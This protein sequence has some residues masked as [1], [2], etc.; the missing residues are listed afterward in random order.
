[1]KP[2]G[3]AQISAK[4]YSGDWADY[5]EIHSFL[6]PSKSACAHFKHRFLLHHAEG[7]ELAVRIFG[8][9]ITN[10]ENRIILTKQILTD[11]LIE[12][13]GRI[14]TIE[15]WVRDLMPK[16]NS[17]FYKFLAKKREQIENDAAGGE[18]K[19][20][21]AFGLKREDIAAIKNFMAFPLETCDHP[22]AL[23]ISH[24]S[25]AVFLAEKIFGYAFLKNKKERADNS[26]KQLVAVREV[27]ERLIFLRLK[28]IYSPAE[29]I[30]RTESKTWMRGA[31]AGHAQ[32][33]KKRLANL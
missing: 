1:M 22:A 9:T 16:Q 5:I 11:H 19:L 14:V 12:D 27:F 10:S 8:E 28:T 17:S 21:E 24:N 29:I 30:A 13:V 4:T 3:H 7:I 15:D 20:F 26:K 6:D 32:A 25:F 2:V 18:R 31:N 33:E 23:L